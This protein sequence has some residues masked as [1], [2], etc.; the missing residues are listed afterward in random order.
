[1]RVAAIGDTISLRYALRLTNGSEILSNFDDA[2]ADAFTLGD[3]TLSPNLEKWLLGIGQGER[4]V[5]IL[6]PEQAFGLSSL[7]KIHQLPAN[8][9]AP[10]LS[11]QPG[12]LVEFTM[13]DGQTLAGKILEL[14]TD[15]IRVDF[16]HPLADLPIEFEVEI[17]Q[18]HETPATHPDTHA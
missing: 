13:P 6:E 10:D 14:G 1:M 4:H 9:I 5:F 7:D 18:F 3:G 2:Q 17:M 11:L 15:T 8:Q 16:N 12:N